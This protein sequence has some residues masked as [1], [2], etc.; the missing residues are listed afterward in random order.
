MYGPCRFCCFL[1]HNTLATKEDDTPKNVLIY[2]SGCQIESKD[3]FLTLFEQINIDDS[4][5]DVPHGDWIICESL[6]DNRN[7]IHLTYPH[8]TIRIFSGFYLNDDAYDAI[9]HLAQVAVVSGD[10]T[11]ERCISMNIMPFYWSTNHHSNKWKTLLALQ[12]I[13]QRSDILLSNE[14]RDSF[15]ILFQSTQRIAC[16]KPFRYESTIDFPKIIEEWSIVVDYLREHKNFYHHLE[17]IVLH[18]LSEKVIHTCQQSIEDK[19]HERL[20]NTTELLADAELTIAAQ[21]KAKIIAQAIAQSQLESSDNISR[22]PTEVEIPPPSNNFSPDHQTKIDEEIQA[23]R[24]YCD[25]QRSRLI[26]TSALKSL[27]NFQQAAE[28]IIILDISSTEKIKNLKTCA[29]RTFAHRH[30]GQ[31]LLADTLIFISSFALIGLVV[32]TMRV[33]K[34]HTFFFSS[35]KTKREKA[36]IKFVDEMTF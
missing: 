17:D 36:L 7:V 11:L 22:Q 30:F 15:H 18:R 35:E 3:E 23:I 21:E 32:G 31:R 2:L 14:A 1:S 29:H 4:D 26:N 8:Y 16:G 19:P 27:E 34:G 9:Y 24:N 25:Q 10:N 13:T 20:H 6:S 33:I 5:I 28:K 12:H